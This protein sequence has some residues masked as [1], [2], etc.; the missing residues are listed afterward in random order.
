MKEI[1]LG[2]LEIPV[3]KPE[4]GV[5]YFTQ[6]DI[7]EIVEEAKI[8][9]INFY[10]QKSVY[11][12][13]NNGIVDNAE[14]VNGHTVEKD[15]PSNA[16]FTDTVYN[17]TEV[18]QD[19]EDLQTNKADKTE[20]PTLL[21]D[22]TED[23]THRTVTDT[24][25]SNW[26]EKVDIDVNN[27]TN[28]ELKTNTGSTIELSI[29]SSTYVMTLNLKNSAGTIISTGTIDLP[30]E[31][32]VVNAS[33]DSTTKEIVLTLQSGS[34][35]R[36]SV[37]DLVSGLQSEITS[38]NKLSSDLVDDTNSINKFVT[39]AEKSTWNAKEDSSN[40]V[41]SINSN[42]TDTQYPS[43]KCVYDIV[44]DIEGIL[45]ELDIGGGV[46]E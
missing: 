15:V 46:S 31:A 3:I 43:A 4:K 18:R 29:N 39:S 9:L 10:M 24:E 6:E 44:G 40:K 33:Y 41:T 45:E 20:I 36:F 8:S 12:T 17:D 21:S 14:Q 27:L 25:K 13:N 34:T 16:V 38:S 19:I 22:L 37:A 42:S 11:D 2:N 7:S 5:D 30:L 26:N 1:N 23:S 28:Y 32:M 35:V